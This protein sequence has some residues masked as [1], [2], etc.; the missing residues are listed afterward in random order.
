[1]LAAVAVGVL[2]HISVRAIAV[3]AITA[4]ADASAFAKFFVSN[5]FVKSI[6]SR[7]LF[8]LY[9]V[10][11]AFFARDISQALRRLNGASADE[12]LVVAG[13]NRQPGRSG[14]FK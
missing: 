11:L 6:Q 4:S 12:F 3:N 7:L 8:G 14:S 9:L 13:G 1:L 10:F 5:F 2:T